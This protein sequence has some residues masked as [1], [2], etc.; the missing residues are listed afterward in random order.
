[1]NWGVV[2]LGPNSY[3]AQLLTAIPIV[4]DPTPLLCVA[5]NPVSL[6]KAQWSWQVTN[7][8][9]DSILEIQ[10]GPVINILGDPAFNLHDN[11]RNKTIDPVVTYT[12]ST[13]LNKYLG[14]NGGDDMPFKR[15]SPTNQ[16]AELKVFCTKHKKVIAEQNNQPDKK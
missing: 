13:N 14:P 4:K 9:S 8:N 7:N 5:Y 11:G 2:S 6:D 15:L 1:M 16:I 3:N 10:L 12:L